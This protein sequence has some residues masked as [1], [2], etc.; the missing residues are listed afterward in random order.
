[1]PT[2]AT[3]FSTGLVLCATSFSLGAIYSNWAY[4]YW[5]LWSKDPTPEAFDNS[6][7]H[8]QTWAKMPT[9][10]HHVHHFIMFLGLC[11]LFA[12]LYRPSESNTLFDGGSLFLFVIAIGFYLTNLRTGAEAALSRV[13][14]DV[15]EMT[16][17]NVIASSQVFI[18]LILLGVI[19]LQIGQYWAEAEEERLAAD[20]YAKEA[21]AK[22]TGTG[23]S[24]TK[25]A[26][27]TKKEK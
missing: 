13:W 2:K 20:F 9:F 27:E 17:I 3:S 12:K 11:G 8:Y 15:D 16:G 22:S 6:L 1:M 7:L 24:A 4:D 21:A 25:E 10:L 19:G 14:G 18:V 23:E 26:K 5:T